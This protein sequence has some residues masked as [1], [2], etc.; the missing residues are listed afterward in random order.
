[1]SDGR[2]A[3][4]VNFSASGTMTIDRIDWNHLLLKA[5]GDEDALEKLVAEHIAERIEWDHVEWDRDRS[6]R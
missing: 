3:V 2:P 5:D 1:M 6:R 4:N